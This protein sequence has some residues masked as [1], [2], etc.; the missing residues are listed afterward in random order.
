MKWDEPRTESAVEW[1]IETVLPNKMKLFEWTEEMSVSFEYLMKVI[2]YIISSCS[3]HFS[4]RRTIM[5][6]ACN[7]FCALASL[8]Y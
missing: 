8:I 3:I 1:N 5:C 4:V 7:V 6:F 2:L